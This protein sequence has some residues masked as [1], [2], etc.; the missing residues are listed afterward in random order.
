MAQKKTVKKIKNSVVVVRTF[1]AGVHVGVLVSRNGR[2]VELA[3]ARRI[4]RWSGA[5]TLNELS[6]MGVDE[7]GS[8]R[9]SEP[10][11]S[12]TLTEAIEVIPCSI[13]GAAN[14]QRS[15]WSS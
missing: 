13:I 12:I 10:V 3:D 14:L 7:T 6:Q 4:W 11:P 5:N 9:I 8:T 2:D 1:S 15:R